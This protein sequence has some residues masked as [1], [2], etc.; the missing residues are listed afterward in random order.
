MTSNELYIFKNVHFQIQFDCTD[1]F[2]Y[3]KNVKY[4]HS[5]FIADS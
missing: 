2:E 4:L 3:E 1:T 5:C